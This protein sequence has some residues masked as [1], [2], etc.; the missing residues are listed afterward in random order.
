VAIIG[1]GNELRG[2]DAA[3]V[4]VV[5]GLAGRV[6]DPAYMVVEGGAAPEN[7]TGTLRDFHPGRV[8]CIDT[9]DMGEEPGGVRWIEPDDIDGLSA[10]THSL[11]LSMC[12]S[13]LAFELG[14]EVA[15]LGIQPETIGMDAAISRP[16]EAAIAAVQS[17]LCETLRLSRPAHEG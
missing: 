4:L 9:A 14:C 13:F 3:G 2:D 11:P 12:A 7:L 17:A 5:R 16:V 8:L 10:S 1:I 15:V 6:V